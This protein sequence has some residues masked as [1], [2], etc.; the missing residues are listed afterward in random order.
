MRTPTALWLCFAYIT[1][2][3]TL[4]LPSTPVNDAP[5]PVSEAALEEH[6]ISLGLATLALHHVWENHSAWIQERH[7]WDSL[8]NGQVMVPMTCSR[9]R[10]TP[11]ISHRNIW[12][13]KSK[14]VWGNEAIF[15]HLFAVQNYL[16]DVC[17][18]LAA[19][20][21]VQG[22]LMGNVGPF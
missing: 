4:G 6:E 18:S 11:R 8:C 16:S 15:S 5:S 12:R 2:S 10:D 21:L 3:T 13:V 19:L 1:F 20:L 22:Q 7:L 9:T 17:V 14:S